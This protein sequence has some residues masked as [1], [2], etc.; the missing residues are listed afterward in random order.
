M[1][2]YLTSY[3]YGARHCERFDSAGERAVAIER[4]LKEGFAHKN[5][6]TRHKFFGLH[7]M[8]QNGNRTA[9]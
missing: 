5:G 2:F 1:N 7:A 9:N 3:S 6:E 4:L 8:H